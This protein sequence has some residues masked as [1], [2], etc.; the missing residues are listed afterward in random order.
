MDNVPS[1]WHLADHLRPR[2]LAL[3]LEQRILFDGAAASAADH[4]HHADAAHAGAAKASSEPVPTQDAHTGTAA[5]PAPVAA[6]AA[7]APVTP[8][9][10]VVVDSRVEN[11]NELL[12]Q[13]PAG[14][15]VLVVQPGQDAISAITAALAGMGHA[16]SVQIFSHGAAGQFTLGNQIFTSTTL[17]QMAN[18]LGAWRSHLSRGADIEL[19]GCDIGAGDAGKALVQ[20]LAST[21]G[22]TVGASNDAT[23]SAALGGDWTLEVTSGTLDKPIALSA[24]A[25]AHYDHLLA[26]ASPSVTLSA[27]GQDVLLGNQFTF[28]VSFTN[29]STQVGYAP[30]V[31]LLMPATGKDGNDGVSFVSAS[32]LG[33]AVTSFVVTFDANGNAIHPLAKDASGNALVIHAATY[34]LRPGDELVVLELPFASVTQGQ[35]AITVQVNAQLSNL[36]DTAFSD[37]SPD[38]TIGAHGGFQ[39]GNDSLD[40]PTTDPT[41]VETSVHNFLVQPTVVSLTQTVNTPEGET[42]TGPN[43]VRSETVTA[44]AAPGQTITDV[45]IN[46]DIPANVQVTAITPGAGGTITSLTLQDGSVLTNA[47]LINAAINSD[48]VF[49]RSYSVEYA[50]ITGSVDTVVSFYVPQT[51]ASGASVINPTTGAPVTIAFGTASGSGQWVPLDPRDLTP[52]ATS[53][54]FSGTAD[55][56]GTTFVAKAATLEKQ[57]SEQTD[58]GTAGVTP[59][60]TLA[61]ALDVALSDYFALGKTQTGAGQFVV[62]DQ[63]G[64]GQTLAGTPTLTWTQDGVVH[65]IALVSTRTVNADG[66][67]TLSFDIGASIAAAGPLQPGALAGDIASDD[68]QQGAT[69]ARIDYLAVVGQRYATNYTQSDINEGDAFGNH[70]T[71][72]ATLLLDRLNLTGGSVSDDSST[73]STV[74]AGHVDIALVTVNGTTPPASGEL[75]PGDVVTF[76]LSYNL[77]TG[78]YERF[79]LAAYLPLPLLNAT[80]IAWTQGSGVGQWSFGAGNTN[81]GSLVSVTEGSGNSLV[82]DFGSFATNTVGGSTIQVLFTMRVG[83]QPYA[84]NRPFDVLA[85]SNQV[86]TIAHTPLVSSDVA[87]VASVAEPVLDMRQGVVSSSDGVVSGTTGAW[88][89][90]GSGGV[91]F[92]G[93]VTDVAAVDGNVSGIDGGDTVRLATAIKNS[94]GGGAYDVTTT[95]TLPGGL[96]FVGGSLAAAD[97]AI[98]RGDGTRLVAGTDYSVSGNTI[99]FL[100]AGNAATL[101]AGRAGSAADQAGSNVVVI[102]YDA[103]AIGSIAAGSTLQ[104]SAALTRY[105]SV[106]GGTDFTPTDLVD[107]ASEQ[108]AAPTVSVQYG[109]GTLDDADSSASHTSGS[110]LV[111]GENMTYDIVVTLPEGST[112]NLRVDDLIPAGL[113]LDTSFNGGLGYQI[114]TT[115]AGSAALGAD[116]NGTVS[117]ASLAALSGQLGADSAGARW[118]FAASSAAADNNAGNDAFVIRV[119]LVASNTA[120]NQ[121]GVTLANPGQLVYSDPDGDTPNGAS[122]LDRSVAQSGTAPTVVIREPTLQVTQTT[123][124]LPRLG[125]DE[126]DTVEYDITI[127]NGSAATDFNA[128]DIGF[129]DALPAQLGGL[130]I[131]GVSYQ[132]GATNHGGPDF[133]LVNGQLRT[134]T[135]ANIDIAKGGSVTLRVSGTVLASAASVPSFDNTATVQW[136]SLDGTSATTADPAGERTGADGLLNSGA[137]N[138]YRTVST[139]TV[140]VAQVVTISR[141]GGLAD[142]PA[143]SPTD[144]SDERVTVGELVRYRVVSLLAEGATNDYSVQITLQNGLRF[145]NDGTVRIVFI[146]NNGI[147]TDIT[148]LVTGGT[149]NETGN[150]TS[151]EALP[152]TPDLSGAAPTGV[153]NAANIAVTTDASGNEVITFR[154]GNIV[155]PD[156]D[157]DLEGISLEFNA[158]VAN[159]A[160]NAAGAVLT[161]SAVDRSGANPLTIADTVREDIVEPTFTGLQ[162]QVYGF[163]PGTGTAS[164]TADVDV[165]FTQ[166]GTS[167]AYDVVLTDSFTGATNYTFD[168]LVLNGTTYTAAQLAGIG[169]AVDTTSGLRLTFAELGVNA[170]VQVFYSADV[171]NNAAIAPTNATLTWTSLPDSFTNW[172]GSSVGAAGSADGERTGAGAGAS[173]NT[174]IRTSAAGLGVIGGTLWDDTASATASATPD[175]PGLA[176]QS[177]TLTWAGVDGNLGTTA[178]NLVYTATTD[179]SGHYAFGVLPLGVYRIQA[180]TGTITYPQPVGALAVRIDSDAATALGTVGITLADGGTASANAGYVEQND[181]PVNTLP[182]T[183]PSGL[184]DTTFSLAGIS[185]SDVDAGSG[186][187]QVTL[188]VLHGTLSLTALP[189]GVTETGERTATLT[190]TGTLASLNSALA[191]LQYLGNANFNGPD[192]LTV[193]TND[194]GNFGDFNG[195]GIPGEA[196]DARIAVS[197]LP[198]TVIAVNDPPVANADTASATEA[199]G[200]ANDTPGVNPTGNVLANDTDVDI[201]TNGDALRVVQVTNQSGASVAVPG[202]ARV[203]V[204][205][206]YGTLSIGA[207]GGYEYVVDNANAAVQALRLSG[208][209]L[210]ERFSYVVNDSANAAASA[211]LTVTIHGANDT[212]IGVD[213]SGTATEAGGVANGTPGSNATGNVLANDTDVDSAAN[214]ET[215][216][217]TGITHLP[218]SAVNGPL[219]AVAA[220]TT[221]GNG[222]VIAGAYGTLTIGADGSYRYVIDNNNAQVQALVPA[223]APLVETFTYALADAGGLSDLAQLTIQIHGA[224]DN[225]VASNDAGAARAGS[226]STG[227]SPVDATGNVITQASRPGTPTQ[228][229]GNGIDTDVDHT[230]NPDTLLVVNGVR[231]GTE[232]AGGGLVAVAAGTGAANGTSIAGSYGTLIIGANGA[233]DYA[234]DSSNAA[235]R[236]LAP[237]ATLTETFTYRIVDTSGLADQAQ[238]VITVTGVNDAPTPQTDIGHAVEAG[239][240]N[241]GTP[242]VDPSGNVLANDSDPDQDALAVAAIRTGASSGAGTAGVVGQPLRGAYST[243]TLGANGAWQYTVDNANAQ[244]QALRTAADILTERFTYTV[245]DSHGATAQAELDVVIS[246]Q[247]DAPVAQNDLAGAMEAGGTLNQTPG[248]DPS[249]NVL[250]NDTDV[251]AGDTKTVDGVRAGAEAVPASF[252]A[253]TG[254]TSVAGIYGT[255]TINP[256]GSYRYVVDNTLPAVQR[257]ILGQSVQETFTYRMHDTAGA[258]D[259]AQITVQIRGAFDAPVA[260]DDFAV[261]AA[262]NGNGRPFDATGNVLNNDTDVDQTDTLTGNAI[263]TGAKGLGGPLSGLAPGSSSNVDATILQGQYGTLLIGANGTYVY[264]V[265]TTNPTVIALGPLQTVNDV[266]TYRV[267]DNDNLT[268]LGQ[269]TIVVRGRNDAP[270]ARDDAATAAEAG[271]VNNATPGVNP[272]G[273]VLANDTDPDGDAI[274]VSAVQGDSGALGTLLQ[275]EYGTL[276]MNA[277]GT[278]HYTVDNA[279]AAV[280]ALRT[281]GQTLQDVFTYTTEDFLGAQGTAQL[282]VTIEGRNDA[283]VAHDDGSTA[284]EAGGVNNGTPG[285]DATGNVLAN[286]TDVDSAA[287]GETKQVSGISNEAGASAAAGTALAGRYGELIV[288]ADGSYDYSV[289]NANAAVQALRTNGDTLTETFVYRM[290]DTAG[291]TSQATLTITIRGTDDAPVARD[292]SGVASDQTP[293]PQTKGNVLANDGDVDAGDH[294]DVVGVQAQTG[295]AATPGH[296]LA[297]RYGTLELNAD[298]S[299]TYSIDLTNPQ[300]LAAAGLGQVLQD[301][302]TYTVADTAGA[303]TQ[304][305]L[306]IHLDIS[307]PYIPPT[308][309]GPHWGEALATITSPQT[310]QNFVPAVFVTP[311]VEANAVRATER[312]READ[313]SQVDWPLEPGAALF[314][315]R[316]MPELQPDQFVGHAVRDS[317]LVSTFDHAWIFGRHGR[318]SLDADGLLPDPSVFAALAHHLT[319]GMHPPAQGE[320]EKEAAKTAQGFASQLHEAARKLPA[321]RGGANRR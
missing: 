312:S 179:A 90:P 205:G 139:L 6:P 313:G 28:N 296:A 122:A 126:G 57:V 212:P 64:D 109:G 17:S 256:D 89:A 307:T 318:V 204:A 194:R 310:E 252:A 43:F 267:R 311:V 158:R 162:K 206:V 156:N 123:Q 259:T 271:G 268:D 278:W 145:I 170:Q 190:L 30:Y 151:P 314:S 56:T 112:R 8:R 108:V 33:Q 152:I 161:A 249:G 138:D 2:S 66:T 135:G 235:V 34:G 199:G 175:G 79:S 88:N 165:R 70:A 289:D 13:T 184:E 37:S 291:A 27:S 46:Q 16:D 44:T 102:T 319:D 85:Q 113:R 143:P 214:G 25:L 104:T 51:D 213:D 172:G 240:V 177:V 245:T 265:D 101:L 281:S 276:T 270:V 160:S 29:T 133:E 317:Q 275:G 238:L 20:T 233:Y 9:N 308:G 208:Q 230:D 243:L 191:N 202:A 169:A 39:Y 130:S 150:E 41:I 129:L 225:P 203:V 237:G 71:V 196:G 176:G 219:T 69:T 282:R 321:M 107:T 45:V 168:H 303:T 304:A 106:E 277:D 121:A 210:T 72:A 114:I 193:T 12:A 309:E 36:A 74:P 76:S 201:A 23:G 234:V 22:A 95:V 131:L 217:V 77:V 10:L 149:L 224:N 178:D 4:Q 68:V 293:A 87:V 24:Y 5:P 75:N 180:P 272:S 125:V 50:S 226:A 146:S 67:T 166:T 15:Q 285:R 93:T 247:N 21:T 298:G 40:N 147:T 1:S 92:A 316:S 98:Y 3:A 86:T 269:L 297:G 171:P 186:A 258:A 223:D 164:G 273:N 239:G 253:V 227:V 83:D 283:P 154:L 142:T 301:V 185:V 229:G 49:I 82:F 11:G 306:L 96:Q 232:A 315:S 58:T 246:G 261:A 195:N 7:V 116:F 300:V 182:G 65:T 189:A 62:T 61:Y 216:R 63:L 60:D 54:A 257:L 111:I 105:A 222:L 279:S 73:T 198:I 59:G 19:Y 80:G 173:P 137:L 215:H 274:H 209:T 53:V 181:A 140:P 144:A 305:Q 94:G 124:P 99:T 220:G 47:A 294:L 290:R 183:T 100:D 134:A 188:N 136:T 236:A 251:D 264:R 231:P 292:D 115:A 84:D 127:S 159:Q 221:S 302:F 286:D 120:G 14:T 118:T 211:T 280:Q 299:Y 42:A 187:L 255:F 55:G 128:F 241:N 103:A 141:V 26:D 35:P 262:N 91:P 207:N 197:T 266:F 155:N 78:D 48:T 200:N 157:A 32:Y 163:D 242:G 254:A 284:I 320:T 288:K 117:V 250:L 153:L 244:V 295:A 263:R 248:I 287:N 81:P 18:A 167:P 119:H 97:L 228:P 132:N 38:L 192:T 52:P 218:E 31:D 110:D 174:Y 260:H 148:S